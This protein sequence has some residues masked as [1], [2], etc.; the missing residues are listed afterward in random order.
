MYRKQHIGKCAAKLI[1]ETFR[2]RWE[3][4]F[5]EKNIGAKALWNQI[6]ASYHPARH[7]YS[8]DGTVLS[9]LI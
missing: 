9:F 3:I 5:N 7:R 8:V 1:L 4:K 6:T 2:G